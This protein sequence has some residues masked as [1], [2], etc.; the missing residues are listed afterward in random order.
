MTPLSLANQVDEERG[1]EH[2]IPRRSTARCAFVGRTL[3]GPVNK[4]C[5]LKSFAEFQLVFGGLW[6][7]SPLGYAVEH[8]FDNGG[9]EAVVVR[10][11]NGARGVTLRLKAGAE[12]L[13]LLAVRPGTREYLR[14]SVDYDNIP[15]TEI[16]SFNLTVQRVRTLGTS[17]VED[18]EIFRRISL[19]PE[20][21]LYASRALSRSELVRLA[22]P[23]PAVRPDCTLGPATDMAGAWVSSRGDGDDGAPLTDYDVIGSPLAASGIFA[24]RHAAAFNFLCVPPLTRDRDVGASLLL[25]ASRFCQEQGALLLVD[26][27]AQWHTVDDALRALRTWNFAAENAVMFFPRLLAH[28]KL[29][30]RFETFAPCGAVAGMLARGDESSPVWRHE[31]PA[32]Q[33]LRPGFRPACLVSEDGRQRLAAWG[34]NV[35]QSVRSAVRAAVPTRL[36]HR[37]LARGLAANA[38]WQLLAARRFALFVVDSVERGTRWVL[39][40]NAP[41][42]AATSVASQVRF[43][44]ASLHQD[45][46]FGS[47]QLDEAFFVLSSEAARHRDACENALEFLVGFAALRGA[48]FHCFRITHARDGTHVRKVTLNRLQYSPHSPAELEW[49]EGLAAQIE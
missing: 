8:F 17:Q 20:A 21:H 43:F 34:V 14:A 39:H 25:I 10:V 28:D 6:Q 4:P 38:D 40:Q 29:R 5:L 12:S 27:P 48:G 41:L 31:Q 9:R 3:R 47:R 19:L 37:T 16:S 46:A 33:L 35:A 18:Q 15:A 1:P 22:E 24:L 49:V 44:F 26:P 45:G 23:L 32:D 30:G 7:P 2:T 11:V 36:E 13:N 42:A